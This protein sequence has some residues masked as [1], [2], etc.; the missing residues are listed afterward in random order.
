MP[1]ETPQI[2]LKDDEAQRSSAQKVSGK[3]AEAQKKVEEDK[4]LAKK[5]CTILQQ[6]IERIKPICERITEVRTQEPLLYEA[7]SRE[8]TADMSP[9]V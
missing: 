2:P 3:E 1:V 8:I 5:M 6:T 9:F 4:N 7:L